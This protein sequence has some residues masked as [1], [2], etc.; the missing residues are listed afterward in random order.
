MNA[1]IAD[2]LQIDTTEE[3][4]DVRL[5]GDLRLTLDLPTKN[6]KS[7]TAGDEYNVA[8]GTTHC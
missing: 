8:Q 1:H 3:K 6:N 7:G 2:H 4:G 5:L